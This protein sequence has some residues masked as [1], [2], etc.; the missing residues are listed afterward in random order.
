MRKTTI[1]AGLL[2]LAIIGYMAWP[3]YTLL[4]L[5]RAVETG[6]VAVAVAH[7]NFPGVRDS[8]GQQ[9]LDTYLELTGKR[10]SPLVRGLAA[11]ASGITDPIVGRI[12]SPE[13][14]TEFLRT[15]WPKVVAT[16][17]P[18][19]TTGLTTG[20]LGTAWQI[21]MNTDYGIRR[22]EIAVPT[23]FA[24]ERQI[25][26]EFRIVR[27]RWMLSSIRLPKYIRVLLAEALIKSLKPPQR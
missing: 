6:N 27:W 11:S 4:T 13:A 20:N 17:P 15:G 23:S 5:T 25:G 12:V 9:I 22:F 21:F 7:I 14:L 19:G 10:V 2:V 1:I 26:F 3:L 8:L 24:R 18:P 16:D